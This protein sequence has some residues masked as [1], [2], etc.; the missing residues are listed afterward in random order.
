MVYRRQ[1]IAATD[2]Q[3]LSEEGTVYHLRYGLYQE[4]TP[5]GGQF[6][7]IACHLSAWRGKSLVREDWDIAGG[8]GADARSA[9]VVYRT[10]AGARDPVF[11]SHLADI[12]REQAELVLSRDLGR[13]EVR[14]PKEAATSAQHGYAVRLP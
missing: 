14:R 7:A 5:T 6:Y 10:V 2:R 1:L 4:T 13:A 11:P 8:L 3:E 9:E 12:V